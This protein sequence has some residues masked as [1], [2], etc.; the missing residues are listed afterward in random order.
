MGQKRARII[1]SGAAVASA[2]TCPKAIDLVR[3]D[4]D[5]PPLARLGNLGFQMGSLNP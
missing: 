5:L 2:K 4:F 3:L 1:R